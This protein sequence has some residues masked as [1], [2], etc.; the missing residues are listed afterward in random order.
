MYFTLRGDLESL[1]SAFEEISD[2]EQEALMDKLDLRNSY[3]K[4]PLEMACVLGKDG[5]LSELIKRGADVNLHTSNGYTP[6]HIAACWGSRPCLEILVENGANL[7]ARN[8]HGETAR[9]AA[10]R[11]SME[12]CTQYLDWADARKTLRDF[13]T[14]LREMLSDPEKL[15]GVKLTKDE[16]S[17]VLSACNEKQEWLDTNPEATASDF[18]LKKEEL[19]K[20]VEAITTKVNSPPPNTGSTGKK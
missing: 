20:D 16:K 15:Q 11:Y 19:E 7:G 3:G 4:T 17:T 12:E 8:T 9:H 1:T 2:Q 18:L 5:I 6:L 10:M 14:H 13:M